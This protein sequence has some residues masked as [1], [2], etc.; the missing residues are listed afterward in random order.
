MKRS[1][2]LIGFM[3]AGKTTVGRIAADRLHLPFHDSDREIEIATGRSPAEWIQ[4][5]GESAWRREEESWL[6]NLREKGP[7]VL[8]L[9]GGAFTRYRIRQPLHATATT[10]WLD[11]GYSQL[12]HRLEE[13][14][15]RPLWPK[16]SQQRRRLF[17]RRSAVYSLAERRLCLTTESPEQVAAMVL[18]TFKVRG[19]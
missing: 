13:S 17:A 4:G 5:A 9:G 16:S 10:I 8:A 2:V 15:I 3:G 6:Q 1:L 18:E 14:E 19:C 12:C 11:V 7:A